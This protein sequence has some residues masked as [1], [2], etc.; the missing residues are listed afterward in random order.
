MVESVP[1]ETCYKVVS[2]ATAKTEVADVVGG[3]DADCGY[4][5]NDEQVSAFAKVEREVL[6]RERVEQERPKLEQLMNVNEQLWQNDFVASQLVR[7]QFR[8][9]KRRERRMKDSDPVGAALRRHGIERV[10]GDTDAK[11]DPKKRTKR[12]PF[13]DW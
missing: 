8:E 2:G 6:R 1:A 4:E 9:Q 12:Q 5:D 11:R 13:S 10:D 3:A 7:R